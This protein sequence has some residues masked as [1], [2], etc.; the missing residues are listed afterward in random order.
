MTARKLISIYCDGSSVGNSKGATGWGW[1]I[2]DWEDII[3]AGSEGSPEGTNNTAELQAAIHG[4]RAV[5]DRNLHKNNDVEVVSDSTYALGLANGTYEPSTHFELVRR[6]RLLYQQAT[7]TTRWVRGH[8]GD[9]FNDKA[10]ELAKAGRDRY[11]PVETKKRRRHRKREERRRKRA[12]VKRY[13]RTYGR[14]L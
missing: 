11:M 10:D 6:L 2:T 4:L 14:N 9:A 1:V 13:L 7:A 8:S 3:C 12:I 5:I